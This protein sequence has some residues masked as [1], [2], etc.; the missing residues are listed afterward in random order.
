MGDMTVELTMH[1]HGSFADGPR[2]QSP[3]PVARGHALA[4]GLAARG[5]VLGVGCRCAGLGRY[6][7][8]GRHEIM[9]SLGH[10]KDRIV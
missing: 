10:T 2:R 9:T 3:S 1:K 7:F 6:G 4:Y 5:K 8:A